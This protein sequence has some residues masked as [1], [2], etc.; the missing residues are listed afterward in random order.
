MS[1]YASLIAVAVG[2]LLYLLTTLFMDGVGVRK[3]EQTMSDGTKVTCFVTTGVRTAAMSCITHE[4][5]YAE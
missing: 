4:E 2:V 1:S 5:P 3:F